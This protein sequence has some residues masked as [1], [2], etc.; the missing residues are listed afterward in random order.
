MLQNE[1]ERNVLPV[2]YCPAEV[3]FNGVR[4]VGT[5][6]NELATSKVSHTLIT[7]ERKD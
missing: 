6:L 7:T 1:Y 4:I 5:H 3:Q 2:I